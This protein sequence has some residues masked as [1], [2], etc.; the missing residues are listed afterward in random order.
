MNSV[1]LH[2][3]MIDLFCMSTPGD[4][5]IVEKDGKMIVKK[6]PKD[7]AQRDTLYQDL[8]KQYS[9]YCVC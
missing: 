2:G 9:L 7:K 5:F 1:I 8:L 4:R 6:W 3:E